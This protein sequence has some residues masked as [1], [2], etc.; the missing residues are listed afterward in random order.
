MELFGYGNREEF[1]KVRIKDLYADPEDRKK[2][3]KFIDEH[4]FSRDYPVDLRKKD[5][6]IIHALVTLGL[7]TG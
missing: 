1:F 2:H 5:G 3:L 7:D 4:G 6:T